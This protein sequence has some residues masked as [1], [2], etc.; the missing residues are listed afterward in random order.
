MDRGRSPTSSEVGS[1]DRGGG[2]LPGHTPSPVTSPV[3][4]TTCNCSVN[5][6][7]DRVK[8][9]PLNLASEQPHDNT[10]KPLWPISQNS[11]IEILSKI[12]DELKALHKKI[13]TTTSTPKTTASTHIPQQPS[14]STVAAGGF[15]GYPR[16]TRQNAVVTAAT[17][18]VAIALKSP[19]PHYQRELIAHCDKG[20]GALERPVPRLVEDLQRASKHGEAVGKL[21]SL[22][23]L[24]S[25][26]VI[27]R[28]DT[29][30]SRDSWKRCEKDWMKVLGVGAHLKERHYAVLIHSM[31]K[32]ECQDPEITIA[33]IYRT[34]PRLKEAGVRILRATF[35]KKTL[36]STKSTGPLLVTVSEP[37][38]ANE[39]VR[40]DIIWRY[41][42]HPCE[43]F[44]GNAKP[45]QCF[46]CHGFGHMAMH[47]RQA[48]RC[49]Y[50]SRTG[51]KPEECAVKDDTDAHKCTNCKGKHAAWHREC[52]RVIE[53]RTQ[54]QVAF[55][56]RPTRYRVDTP[57][58]RLP[59]A[60]NIV[61][62]ATQQLD[63]SP[64]TE[65]SQERPRQSHQ[66]KRRTSTTTTLTLNP[67]AADHTT[68]I[69]VNLPLT[70]ILNSTSSAQMRIAPSSSDLRGRH[71]RART[72]SQRYTYTDTVPNTAET[73]FAKTIE[74]ARMGEALGVRRTR[75]GAASTMGSQ[76]SDACEDSDTPSTTPTPMEVDI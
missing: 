71:K 8:Q 41:V 53:Q 33:E 37:E 65:A 18:P 76:S 15:P 59:L 68:G 73:T 48:Q 57:V 14:W 51:H 34:N 74:A 60:S 17:A 21:E 72:L 62:N 45:T 4:H 50:C 55:N 5:G 24:Q 12:K 38:H 46:K 69:A 9:T 10:L 35:Q 63:T 40:Q 6:S 16:L 1:R 47:C 66:R 64:P 27:L 39:M 36:K 29:T 54:A 49:G 13:D 52:P 2:P 25:G 30:E 58:I 43:L 61:P 67:L 11:L 3:P 31:K 70:Q 7:I 22:R 44:E 28:F 42:G 56:N 32:S 75:R 23:K 20:A 19:P 26:D